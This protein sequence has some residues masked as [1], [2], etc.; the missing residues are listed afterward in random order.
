M[1]KGR[2]RLRRREQAVVEGWLI[3]HDLELWAWAPRYVAVAEAIRLVT[4]IYVTRIQV[5]KTCSR[6]RGLALMQWYEGYARPFPRR[7][8]WRA[9]E[10]RA[11]RVELELQ[12]AGLVEMTTVF[13]ARALLDRGVACS[14]R[15]VAEEAAVIGL[16]LREPPAGVT[17]GLFGARFS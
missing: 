14:V 9:E 10:R 7:R 3:D 4:G 15:L 8:R 17:S 13:A 11:M 16:E 6:L 5:A 2:N 1:K 12:R